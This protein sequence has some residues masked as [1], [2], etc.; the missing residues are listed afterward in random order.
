MRF[1]FQGKIQNCL[2]HNIAFS[3]CLQQVKNLHSIST[4]SQKRSGQLKYYLNSEMIK[5]N[6]WHYFFNRSGNLQREGSRGNMEKPFGL[7]FSTGLALTLITK[8]VC[9]PALGTDTSS[10]KW[11]HG[12]IVQVQSLPVLITHPSFLHLTQRQWR[13]TEGSSSY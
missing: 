5:N 6:K 11:A 1:T 2:S 12:I 10:V 9:I 3:Q 7:T 8:V 4:V 13:W